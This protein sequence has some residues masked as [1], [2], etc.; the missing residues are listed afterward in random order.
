MGVYDRQIATATRLIAEKGQACLWRVPGAAVGGTPA[1]P[2]PAGP[3]TDYPVRVVFLSNTSRESL[4]GFLSMLANTEVPSG[5]MRALMSGDVPFTPALT[6]TL[7][8]GETDAAPEL[9]LHD[10]NGI[11][12]LAP[13]GEPILYFLRFQR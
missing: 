6:H 4:A 8:K 5:G 11:D 7:F 3:P 1:S 13:N 2:G 9:V 12:L 10:K